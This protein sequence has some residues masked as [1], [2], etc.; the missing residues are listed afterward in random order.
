MIESDRGDDYYNDKESWSSSMFKM[1]EEDEHDFDKWFKGL[2]PNECEDVFAKGQY[3]HDYMARMID[4]SYESECEFKFIECSDKRK[5]EYKE[6]SAAIDRSKYY[7]ITAKEKALIE[8]LANDFLRSDLFQSTLAMASKVEVEV[9]HRRKFEDFP[10]KGK[11]DLEITIGK[12]KHVFDW[13]T[14]SAFPEFRRKAWSYKYHRQSFIYSYISNAS[15]F[16]FV[17]FDMVTMKRWKMYKVDFSGSFYR[18]GRLSL[19][20]GIELA[21]TYIEHGVESNAFK[22]ATI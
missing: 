7:V 10:L 16:T 19:L 3:L 2:K 13:K 1:L 9:G 20:D 18:T 21:K 6:A 11:L 4:R 8:S 12:K 14:S 5:K 17:V 15:T 22:V